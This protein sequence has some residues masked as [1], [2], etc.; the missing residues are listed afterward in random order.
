MKRIALL[1]AI[2]LIGLTGCKRE[3]TFSPGSSGTVVNQTNV[4]VNKNRGDIVVF[5]NNDDPVHRINVF[6]APGP[7]P[8][9]SVPTTIYPPNAGAGRPSSFTWTIPATATPPAAFNWVCVT[10]T[11]EFGTITVNP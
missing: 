3:I 1:L 7:A 8:A 9:T 10:H 6:P 5:T 11:G 2:G 4:S